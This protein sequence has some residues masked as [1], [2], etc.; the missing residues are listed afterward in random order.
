MRIVGTSTSRWGSGWGRG[1]DAEAEQA[2]GDK[3][4]QTATDADKSVAMA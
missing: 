3:A 4:T 1:G 2:A